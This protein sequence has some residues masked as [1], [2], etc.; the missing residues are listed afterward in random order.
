MNLTDNKAFQDWLEKCPE[1]I[2]VLV[3]GEEGDSEMRL[4]LPGNDEEKVPEYVVDLVLSGLLHSKINKD[5]KQ[6]MF[7][8]MISCAPEEDENE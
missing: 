3:I 7:Q 1:G 6:E 8:R 4:P 5:L 2:A